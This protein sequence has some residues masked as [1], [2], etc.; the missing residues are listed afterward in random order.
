ML[1]ARHSPGV[2]HRDLPPLPGPIE[3]TFNSQMK[4]TTV[5]FW[6]TFSIFC[7]IKGFL[8]SPTPH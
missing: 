5:H 4:K 8:F 7:F 6:L 1:S 3:G 2:P